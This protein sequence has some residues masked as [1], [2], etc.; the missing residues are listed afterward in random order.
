[1]NRSCSL[2]KPLE[3]GA[4]LLIATVLALVAAVFAPGIVP[5]ASAAM[6]PTAI[7]YYVQPSD[8]TG[9]TSSTAYSWGCNEARSDNSHNANSYV[10][11]DFGAQTA[12]GGGTYLPGSTQ[13]SFTNGKIENF[14]YWFAAGY[15]FCSPAHRLWV[16]IA[17]N[18]SRRTNGELGHIWGLIVNDIANFASSHGYSSVTIAAGNDIESWGPYSDIN[19]WEWGTGG[20]SYAGTSGLLI[21]DFG[22]ADGCPTAYHQYTDR[23][24]A[25]SSPNYNWLMSKYYWVSWGWPLNIANPEIYVAAQSVQWANISDYGKHYNDLTPIYFEGPMSAT[26]SGL[27]PSQSW[28]SLTNALNTEGV[29]SYMPY[30]TQIRWG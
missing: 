4:D 22:S 20:G 28:T 23:T 27:T 11:L 10:T 21:S 15:Q 8:T 13:Y 9:S 6:P 1:M 2:W 29:P 25:V 18:N 16:N 14:G 3:R 17:T 26:N 12:G 7:S 19:A 5:E 24:C 30:S